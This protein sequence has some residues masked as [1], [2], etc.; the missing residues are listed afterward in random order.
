MSR[1]RGRNTGPERDLR[2]DLWASGLRYRLQRRIEGVRT[3]L[4]FAAHRLCV[5]VDG[6]FWH[7]CPQHYVP[8][9]GRRPFWSAKLR[10]NVERDRRQ[11]LALEVAG[12]RVLR[13]WEH[14]VLETPE[15]CVTTVLALTKGRKTRGRIWRV[16]EVEFVDAVGDRERRF[17]EDLR[18]ARRRRTVERRRITTKPRNVRRS[19]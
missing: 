3:D 1:I 17:E 15:R 19:C 10:E 7:G 5:F 11:T 13:F 9:R 18:S 16:I 4:Y 8:P 6:C 2:R 12:Y 14:D